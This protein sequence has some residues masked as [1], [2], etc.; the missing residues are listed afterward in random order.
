MRWP[1]CPLKVPSSKFC[2]IMFDSRRNMHLPSP[3]FFSVRISVNYWPNSVD[4]LWC[5]NHARPRSLN[6][7]V[8]KNKLRERYKKTRV[9]FNGFSNSKIWALSILHLWRAMAA[10]WFYLSVHSI[11]MAQTRLEFFGAFIVYMSTVHNTYI[12]FG[13]I[14]FV[15]CKSCI[16]TCRTRYLFYLFTHIC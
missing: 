3:D 4:N 6:P 16:Y 15:S 2:L 10:I 13:W 7:P 1:V 14:Q 9:I 5:T 11:V 8:S 12:I